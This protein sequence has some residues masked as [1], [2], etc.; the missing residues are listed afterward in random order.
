MAFTVELWSAMKNKGLS[1]A[2]IAIVLL[3]SVGVVTCFVAVGGSAWAQPAS[4]IAIVIDDQLVDSDVPPVIIDGRTLV[5]LRVISEHLGASVNWNHETKTVTV[6][7]AGK[8][9]ALRI[10]QAQATVQ[11]QVIALDVP[12]TIISDRTMVPLRFL[13]ETFG[14]EVHWDPEVRRVSVSRA[15][16]VLSDVALVQDNGRGK[17][18]LKLSAPVE[19]RVATVDGE[20]GARQ[21]LVELPG[22]RSAL[23]SSEFGLGAGAISRGRVL[24]GPG[25]PDGIRLILDASDNVTINH[26][27]SDNGQDIVLEVPYQV[28]G[29][30]YGHTETGQAVFIEANG[31]ITARSFTLQG[32]DRIIVDIEGMV[33]AESLPRELEVGS[34]LVPRVRSAQFDENTVRVVVDLQRPVE[35]SLVT[36]GNRAVIHIGQ[37]GNSRQP[38]TDP[39][40]GTILPVEGGALSGKRIVIDPGHGGKDPGAISVSGVREKELTLAAAQV[41]QAVLEEAG[42]RVLMTRSGDEYVDLYMRAELANEFAADAFISIHMNSYHN[43]QLSG[44]ETYHHPSA[45]EGRRLAKLVHEEVLKAL[46]RSDRGVRSADFVVLRETTMPAVLVEAGYL[47][48]P[49]EEQILLDPSTRLRLAQAIYQALVR[50]FR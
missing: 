18:I 33:R 5:P 8:V 26:Y 7:S 12:A 23:P 44:T 19:Y 34:G 38:I 35:Y 2:Y 1:F 6:V 24:P 47:S 36:E 39:G 48:N 21:V 43:P 45:D 27:R 25:N 13:G 41:L 17:I 31:P 30:R 4:D 40:N 29:L 46:G 28:V 14:A 37:A 11:D 49:T 32:P 50:F 3:L 9:I 22:T 42:A 15:G 10:G 20:G 16:A